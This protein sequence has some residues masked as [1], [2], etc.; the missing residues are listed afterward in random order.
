VV[1]SVSLAATLLEN[2]AV[3]G[4]DNLIIP[5]FV[6]AALLFYQIG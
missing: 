6:A 2:I 4:L 1:I 3:K 5:L